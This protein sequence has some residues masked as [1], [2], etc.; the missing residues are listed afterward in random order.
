MA[1]NPD[2]V[3]GLLPCPFCGGRAEAGPCDDRFTRWFLGCQ[4]CG[5][6]TDTCKAAD[7]FEAVRNLASSWNKR[8]GELCRAATAGAY[9]PGPA[10]V[11]LVHGASAAVDSAPAGSGEVERLVKLFEEIGDSAQR[12]LTS[13]VTVSAKS[14]RDAAALLRKLQQGAG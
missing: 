10:M 13:H 5:A 2:N 8:N 11:Q 4:S 9:I 1:T 12:S 6:S 14:L 7:R 3:G